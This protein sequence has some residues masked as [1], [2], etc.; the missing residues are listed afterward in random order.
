PQPR[1]GDEPRAELYGAVVQVADEGL[2]GRELAL[3]LGARVAPPEVV[4][5]LEQH[6][7]AGPRV[8]P[9]EVALDLVGAG[10]PRDVSRDDDEVVGLHLLVPRLAQGAGV[11]RPPEPVHVLVAGGREVDVA[12]GEKTH[13][14]NQSRRGGFKHA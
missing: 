5:A 14:R 13:A 6:L 9:G 7:L 3:E 8:E 11:A 4:V 12:D 1:A 10:G 2:V